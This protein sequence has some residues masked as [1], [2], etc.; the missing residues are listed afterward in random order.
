MSSEFRRRRL[1]ASSIVVGALIIMVVLIG[2]RPRAQRVRPPAMAPL[3]TVAVVEAGAPPV[4]I[5]A[6]GTVRPRHAVTLVPQVSGRVVAVSPRLRAGG[7]TAPGDVLVEIEP[8]DFA[9]AVRQARSQVA[10]AE[11]AHA[12]A[13][14]EAAT[15]RL[16]WERARRDGLVGGADGESP[17]PGSLVLR[18]PQLRQAEAQLDAARA[19]LDRA[20]L[21]LARCRVSLPFAGRVVVATA[22][23]GQHVRVGEALAT[24][25]DVAAAEV[26]VMV[27]D[28]DLAWIPLPRDEQAESTAV[29]AVV[30]AVFAGGEHTWS[31]RVRHLGG[32]VDPSSRQVPVVVEVADPYGGQDGRPPLIN[33]MFVGVEFRRPAPAGAVSI[34][35]QALRPGDQVWLLDGEDRLR[36]RPVTVARADLETVL[37]TGGLDPGDRVVTS[38]LQAVA[39]GMTLRV[40]SDLEGVRP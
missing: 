7:F 15:A 9:L 29:T 11:V 14:E 40:A 38:N 16:E 3:V 20:E 2:L 31:A 19:A 8:A 12:L 27:P 33:G 30:R 22:S 23:V 6:W 5:K 17:A 26:T 24:L 25:D 34:A 13:R 39:E 32:A 28:R 4:T 21:D 37:I 10:Q 35:R 18:E 36:I 1:V